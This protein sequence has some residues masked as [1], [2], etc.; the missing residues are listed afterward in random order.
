MAG[1][2]FGESPKHSAPAADA[3]KV[4]QA[5]RALPLVF[6]ENAGQMPVGSAF[7]GRTQHYTVQVRPSELRFDLLSRR[8]TRNITLSFTGSAGAKPEGVSDAGFRTN[9]YEGS[10]PSNW[11]AGIRNY[12]RI[13][14]RQLYPGIDAEFYAHGNEIEHDFLLAPNADAAQLGMHIAGA[15]K[16]ALSPAGDIVLSAEDGALSLHKPV[17][18][19][20]AADGT[21]QRVD[22]QFVLAAN[23]NTADLHFKLGKYDHSRKLV[24]DP[25]ITYATYVSGDAATTPTSLVTDATGTYASGYTISTSTS[26]GATSVTPLPAALSDP[27]THL[28]A[29]VA[30]FA[31]GDQG[32]RIAWLTYYGSNSGDTLANAIAMPSGGSLL[33]FAGQTQATDL[34]GTTGAFQA[35]PGTGNTFGYVAN[36]KTADGTAGST[37]YATYVS[38]DSV[39]ADVTVLSALTVDSTGNVTVAGNSTG[40]AF[41]PTP[42]DINNAGILGGLF[43][44]ITPETSFCSL[45]GST[46]TYAK[47]LVVTLN[48]SLT[49]QV[50]G[51]YVCGDTNGTTG[52]SDGYYLLN[53]VSVV[54][55]ASAAAT[56]TTYYL[57]GTSNLDVSKSGVYNLPTLTLPATIT[58]A[59]FW[60]PTGTNSSAFALSLAPATLTVNYSFYSGGN[61]VDVAH[62][63]VRDAA[64]NVYV[65]GGTSSS[66]LPTSA[67][68]SSTTPTSPAPTVTSLNPNFGAPATSSAGFAARINSTGDLTSLT[69][70]IGSSAGNISS[71]N[72]AVVDA[73]TPSN[74]YLTGQMNDVKATFPQ[75]PASPPPG[76]TANPTGIPDLPA[77]EDLSTDSSG[78]TLINRGFLLEMPGSLDS[79]TY[80][81]YF[82][83]TT[84]TAS[85]VGVA[86]DGATLPDTTYSPFAYVLLSEQP[87]SSSSFTTA[88]AAQQLPHS[89]ATQ[90]AYLAQVA[91]ST[92][93][94]TASI[95]YTPATPPYT[96]NPVGYSA[97]AFS[98]VTLTWPVTAGASGAN[99]VVFNLPQSTFLAAYTSGALTLSGATGT[100]QL[101]PSSNPANLNPGFTCLI[102]QLAA[103]TTATFTL[104]IALSSSVPTTGGVLSIPARAFDAE[105]DSVDLT[106]SVTAVGVPTFSFTDSV[107][108]GTVNGAL[109][110]ADATTPN[111]QVTYTYTIQ[112][113]SAFDSPNTKLV[114]NIDTTK[115]TVTGTNSSTACDPTTAATG[116][117]IPAGGTL[118]Y[119]VTGK[120]IASQF[121]STATGP[122]TVSTPAP[123][124]SFTPITNNS[125]ATGTP[126]S[127]A[128][129]GNATITQSAI[130]TNTPTYKGGFQ[131]GDTNVQLTAT[132]TNS[133][134]N[135]AGSYTANITLPQGFTATAVAPSA[136]GTC[137]PSFTSC[138]FTNISGSSG[139]ATF[140]VT[141][142]FNDTGTVSDAVAPPNTSATPT[143]A[144]VTGSATT[145]TV[146]T[147]LQAASAGV[148]SGTYVGTAAASTSL[149]IKVSRVNAL[150][151]A[152]TLSTPLAS[153]TVNELSPIHASLPSPNDTVTYSTT[154]RNTGISA[155]RGLYFS[156]PV[157][158]STVAGA[159]AVSAISV[160]PSPGTS[161]LNCS[162]SSV[163]A[164]VICFTSDLVA[165]SST[166]PLSPQTYVVGYSVTYNETAIPVAT[167]TGKTTL[168]QTDGTFYSA[169]DTYAVAGGTAGTVNGGTANIT[170][171]LQR[172]ASLTQTLTF[173][174]A[175]GQVAPVVYA[176]KVHINLDEHVAANAEGKNDTLLVTA[177]VS[178]GGSDDAA[179]VSITIPLPALME[180][181]VPSF[182]TLSGAGVT[183]PGTL[184]LTGAT[185]ATM[186]C[187]P[188]SST[189]AAGTA[190]GQLA[191]STAA[192]AATAPANTTTY[193]NT[194]FDGK[195]MAVSFLA[196]FVDAPTTATVTGSLPT[197]IPVYIQGTLAENDVDAAPGS[198]VTATPA[199]S[200]VQRAAH[201]R[202]IAGTAI[203][204]PTY[205]DGTALPTDSG[206]SLPEI[207]QAALRMSPSTRLVTSGK[208]YNCIRYAVSVVNDGPNYANNSVLNYAFN[209]TGFVPVQQSAGTPATSPAP[210]DCAG[211]SPSIAAVGAG[212]ALPAAIGSLIYGG[213]TARTVYLDGFYDAGTLGATN[214][215]SVAISTVPFTQNDYNDSNLTAAGA[216]TQDF[217][218]TRPV[219]L[220]NTPFN[221]STTTGFG[222]AAY[223]TVG[224]P[225][226]NLIFTTVAA[227]GITS[228]NIVNA[229]SNCTTVSGSLNASACMPYGK[230]PYPPDS[231][232]VRNLYQP[233][234]TPTYYQVPTTATIS[235]SGSNPTSVCVTA[236]ASS[237]LPDIFVKPERALLWVM[238][239]P[240]TGTTYNTFPTGY[241]AFTSPLTGDI[242]VASTPYLPGVTSPSYTA[243]PTTITFPQVPQAQ[244]GTVCGTV[245]GL[246][247]NGAAASAQTFGVL[248]PVNFPPYV[249][250]G[251]VQTS[252]STSKG[253]TQAL[254]DVY[255][256]FTFDSTGKPTAGF[257]YDYNDRDPCY[258]GGARVACDDNPYLAVFSF[259]DDS[260]NS[261]VHIGPFLTPVAHGTQ[262]TAANQETT[263]TTGYKLF[264]NLNLGTST[265][266]FVVVADQATGADG[267]N[268]A[269]ASAA[270]YTSNPFFRQGNFLAADYLAG[271][272]T[273]GSLV[274]CDPGTSAS[275]TY[276]AGPNPCAGA[277]S[278]T[279]TVRYVRGGLK[280]AT[281]TLN[282]TANP[283]LNGNYFY[284]GNVGALAVVGTGVGGSGLIP[285]PYPDPSTPPNGPNPQNPGG[286][287]N[288]PLGN[289][290][291]GKTSAAIGTVTPSQSVGFI[292]SWL[293]SQTAA[294]GVSG[295]A[296]N[297]DKYDLAC[298]MVDSAT[299]QTKVSLPQG[300]TCSISTTTPTSSTASPTVY[301]FG[302][303][304]PPTIY[305]STTGNQ[306]ANLKEP[307]L[308]WKRGAEGLALAMLLPVFFLRKRLGKGATLALLLLTLAAAPLLSGCGSGSGTGG[309]SSGPVTPSGNYL[310]RATATPQTAGKATITTAVFEVVVQNAN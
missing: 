206:S 236:A 252:A 293:Q 62:G 166:S 106:Q 75:V 60:T 58:P 245:N 297:G 208:V 145:G 248:E 230:S 250:A 197:G 196:K 136:G 96:P 278:P 159:T 201:V 49:T 104:T 122:F 174:A 256:Q 59:S 300:M 21:H 207:S 251:T 7:A 151:Q 57:S 247:N 52:G 9:I 285:L 212:T 61:G 143:A 123:T 142:K 219:T 38:G 299:Q 168:T 296:A 188:P 287:S 292:W 182:C 3:V 32:S 268:L 172:L 109:S 54:P 82:G 153:N 76:A 45:T 139:T 162:Y 198:T 126:L 240:S 244:P 26:F 22:A 1:A 254:S 274:I 176:D 154:V 165:T 215:G 263:P 157:P 115:L 17:A 283:D 149:N 169:A 13:A 118:T 309:G 137:T 202:V 226:V 11:H 48:A 144:T 291:T 210:L 193:S 286:A 113:T 303:S 117:D 134:P 43:G 271:S 23:G 29:F 306:F 35:A 220:V 284:L 120:Y 179:G 74:I 86:L 288:S 205:T 93:G 259:A 55:G 141:G 99:R 15:Q 70:L 34:P 231:A 89:S 265:A 130:T 155:V 232:G 289:D 83:P 72:A 266:A 295:G 290:G 94:S 128:I 44:L 242:T 229:L 131:L 64:S 253:S 190:A 180:V 24:I 187:T 41:T 255:V 19:Q 100:C 42:V 171:N 40:N 234:K 185:G 65:F 107:S 63:L 4:R 114:T 184:Y 37:Q 39:P 116:C 16:A 78:A 127:V 103:N 238:A 178:N 183:A 167:T 227:P 199:V 237:S 71:V 152:T 90:A 276:I 213:T 88:A 80:R 87:S 108:P 241:P 235:T 209:R 175:P 261:P 163:A 150:S 264:T 148:S 84:G 68:T 77:Q 298:F 279:P 31:V 211:A 92:P 262:F 95:S 308:G 280:D 223:S 121:G 225:T 33:Y 260:S 125:S 18:Y 132:I 12:D 30:K 192:C 186:T 160:T 105:G 135:Q 282:Y 301:T 304:T 224:A 91:F 6:E 98:T 310:F 221:D 214:S 124:M 222:V 102:P 177:T 270:G 218:A 216:P 273:N 181:A 81:A 27:P 5:D 194:G 53:G 25:V 275:F 56:P 189:T 305:V 281:K 101:G 129:N 66:N 243:V 156:I 85:A 28:T 110:A 14:L 267:H 161:V 217:L 36:I 204:T 79:V 46:G 164:A 249:V 138:T 294:G 277:I 51:T 302:S 47:G 170:I 50:Y 307:G 228:T 147:F 203:P 112:N 97:S 239:N 258:V 257:T 195:C 158:Q 10:N 69:Y 200:V 8:A 133:G 246:V 2:A 146:T 73:S 20:I 140:T 119:T 233:G 111:T 67:A 173:A 191:A 269:I 272:G